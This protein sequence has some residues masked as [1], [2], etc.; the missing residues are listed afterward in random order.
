MATPS[1][2]N[3]V[4]STTLVLFFLAFTHS[5]RA[6][7]SSSEDLPA[8]SLSRQFGSGWDCKRGFKRS[9]SECLPVEVPENAYLDAIGSGWRCQRGYSKNRDTCEKINVPSNAYLT[10]SQYGQGWSCERGYRPNRPNSRQGLA[11]CL[12]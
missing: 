10:N 2:C 4:F 12:C 7:P 5:S 9:A 6:Q 8:N 3:K 11:E 1:K